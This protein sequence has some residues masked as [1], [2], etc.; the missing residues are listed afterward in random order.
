M[1]SRLLS[2]LGMLSLALSACGPEDAPAVFDTAA[3]KSGNARWIIQVE[4][5]DEAHTRSLVGGVVT[6]RQ[7]KD[8]V[9]AAVPA[10]K[11][12]T[13]LEQL[14]MIIVT[15]DD[16]A[17]IERVRSVPG[18]VAVF[19]DTEYSLH[20]VASFGFVGQGTALDAGVTG[21]NTAVAVLDTGTDY[22]RAAFGSCSAP[23]GACSVAV[24]RDFA[25]DDGQLDA[26]GHGTNVAGIVVGLAPGTKILALDVFNASGT[27]SSTDIIAAIDWV[28]S[29]KA[30]YNVVAIN[31]SLGGGLFTSSC[32]TDVFAAPLARARTA[33]IVPVVASGNDGAQNAVASPACTPAALTVGALYDGA[34][35]T[36]NAGV[37]VDSTTAAGQV[38]CFSNSSA[39]LALWAPGSFI[40]AAGITMSGTSQATPHV[41]GAIALVAQ[42]F[43]TD[44]VDARQARLTSATTPTVTRAG[45]TRPR[46]W[47]PTALAGCNASLSSS[48]AAFGPKSSSVNVALS[49]PAGCAWTAT[50]AP[51]WLQVSPASGTGAATLKLTVTQNTGVARTA[52]LSLSGASLA[53]SQ[54]AD[55]VAPTG[56][57]SVT[58]LTKVLSI[59]LSLTATD[60]VGVT[61]MCVS[62]ATSCPSTG[63]VSFAASTTFALP[64]GDG[65]KTVRAWFRDARGNVSA[66]ASKTVTLDTTA[67]LNGTLVGAVATGS[68]TLTWS[69]FSDATSGVVK[70][71]LVQALSAT[72]PAS[73]TTGTVLY[74]GTALK[75]VV[76]G[77]TKGQARSF[78]LCAI[79]A[80]GLT[81][82]GATKSLVG[83]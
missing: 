20:D 66:T 53:V 5:S 42:K 76:S 55:T 52:A 16:P 26:H 13:P 54:G 60:D 49:I 71:R 40:N 68:M 3:P 83:L 6:E 57:L 1:K 65:V 62:T 72:A 12:L 78:R 17:A 51:T 24:A 32:P 80:V 64:A 43:P 82:S 33:G 79:D 44:G 39:S 22:T 28:I 47:L 25:P 23:G 61:S 45:V 75:F 29:Q 77:V 46:L 18:V 27:A 38:A 9:L 70:Y 74:E 10:L 15:T 35:G 11:E 58:A 50:G 4:E 67:P 36:V 63:W 37:C 81:S 59:A 56:T 34:F 2:T 8:D 73:C 14:P 19:E 7:R 21:T 69:G 30:T 31:L 48:T 41:A